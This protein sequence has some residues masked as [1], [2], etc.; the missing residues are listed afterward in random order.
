MRKVLLF[1]LI[2]FV[3]SF[4]FAQEDNYEKAKRCYKEAEH[5]VLR[6]DYKKALDTAQYALEHF[7]RSGDTD[8]EKEMR[9]IINNSSVAM[10]RIDESIKKAIKNRRV[11]T[12]MSKED[13]IKSWG[14]PHDIT[15]TVTSSCVHEEWCY[16]DLLKGTGRYVYFKKRIDRHVYFEN[17]VVTSWQD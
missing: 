12:G 13:V 2:F 1:M 4:S 15:R 6:S 9:D 10:S 17:G 5:S 11:V 14:Q 7:L 8:K 16:G 3:T